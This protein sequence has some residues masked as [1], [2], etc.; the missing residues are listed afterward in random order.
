MT[1]QMCLVRTGMQLRFFVD[2]IEIPSFHDGD[3]SD[4]CCM[5]K[6]EWAGNSED[7]TTNPNL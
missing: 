6:L 5:R 4:I 3:F 2:S 1:L 7:A